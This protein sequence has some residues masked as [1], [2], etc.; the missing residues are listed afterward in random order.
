MFRIGRPTGKRLAS[1]RGDGEASEGSRTRQRLLA[2][3]QQV[4]QPKHKD[5]EQLKLP[6]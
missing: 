4:S 5:L 1:H 3:P 6:Y 2:R